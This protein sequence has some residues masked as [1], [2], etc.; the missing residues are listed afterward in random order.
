MRIAR[1]LAVSLLLGSA[2]ETGAQQRADAVLIV[3]SASARYAD[4]QSRVR[5]FLDHFGVPYTVLDIASAPV[6]PDVASYAL[7]II[8]HAGLD[9]AARYLD[10]SEQANI[11]SAVSQGTGLVNFDY[12]LAS[13]GTGR[14][15]YVQDLFGFGYRFATSGEGVLFTSEAPTHWIS[16]R[17]L[18]GEVNWARQMAGA[19]LAAPAG[20]TVLARFQD[21]GDP[22]LV[23]ASYGLGRAVQ[24]A[25]YEWMSTAIRGPV[26][27]LD[28]LVW[29][30]LAWAARKP[31]VMQGM[32]AF[33]TLRVDDAI[34]PFWWVRVANELSLKPWLG[35]FYQSITDTNAL[36]LAS[37]VSGG[38]ATASVHAFGSS[39]FYY[40]HAGQRDLP[41]ATMAANFQDATAWH[42]R[43]GIP[44]SSFVV[45]HFYEIGTNAFSG[46]RSWGV[47]SVATHM[48]PG[49]G[50]GSAWL[51]L[52]PYRL[53]EGGVSDSGLP[54]AYAD[55]LTIPGHPELANQ[56]FECV[57]E[58]RD[59][60]G[61]EW[62]PDATDV[63]GTIGRGTRQAKRALDSMA[64][65]TLFTHEYYVQS[66]TQ[67][68]W[69]STLRG[70]LA[71]LAPYEPVYVTMDHACEYL[72]AKHDSRIVASLFDPATQTLTTDVSGRADVATQ[73]LVFTEA[74]GV[75]SQA[76]AGVPAFTGSARVTQVLSSGTAPT[77]SSVAISPAGPTLAAGATL[78]LTATGAYSDGTSREVTAQVA[79]ASS[80]ASV[81]T[82]GAGG[83]A[84]GVAPGTTTISAALGAVSGSTTITVQ[85][86][87]L[88][89]TTSSLPS[90][91]RD[92]PYQATLAA[93]GGTPPYSWSI[94]SGALPAGLTLSPAGA[95][96]G[97]PTTSG[98][99][100]FAARVTDAASTSASKTLSIP[101]VT[102]AGLSLWPSTAVPATA[103][104]GADS[105]VELGV[106]FRSDASGFITGIR[107]YK[108][109]ANTGTH[110][111][112]LWTSSGTRLASATF[113]GETASGWQQV[114]FATPVAIS[115]GLTY[116]AS[117]HT[118][119][120]H[121]AR[122][123]NYFATA[124]WDNAPLHAPS[125]STSGGNGVFGYG[126]ASTFP[127]GS[128]LAANYWVDVVFSA[129]GP[130]TLSSVAV[131]PASPSVAAG[132]T[133]ALQ[134]VGTYSDGTTQDVTGQASWSSSAAAV[135][136]IDG[137][138]LLTA[139]A[140][141][142]ATITATIGTLTGSTS[143]T[144]T[145][146]PPTVTLAG[147]SLAS[148]AVLEGLATTGTVTL[149]GPAPADVAVALSIGA[150]ATVPATV[151]VPSGAT[152]A[153]F[154]VG[155]AAV[156]ATTA[157]TL[158]AT[159]AGV[160]RTAT[161]S[162]L[163][164]SLTL[165][166]TSV[167]GGTSATGTLT[168]SA[169]PSQ[170]SSI[171]LSSSSG[172]AATPASVTL[173][174][175]TTTVTFQVATSA[176]ASTTTA[177]VTA[178]TG[179]VM[180]SAV[181]TVNPTAPAATLASASV[182]PSA[183]VEGDGATGT[184][185]LTAA[186]PAGGAMVAL[187]SS[188][189]AATVPAAVTVPAGAT[190]ATFAIATSAVAAGT[191]AT[192]T[193]SYAGTNRTATLAIRALTLSLSPA[194]VGGG[195]SSTA[196]IRLSAAVSVPITA[197]VSSGNTAVAAV[198]ATVTVPAG[199]TSATFTV[200]TSSV[201]AT[202]TVAIAATYAG[203]AA[204]ASLS[205]RV[206]AP[207]AVS[208]SP[209][210]V[211]GGTPSTGTVTLNYPAPAGGFL[212]TLASSR[213]SAATVPASLTVPAG[214]RSA[215]FPITTFAVQTNTNTSIS[216]SSGGVKKS[217]TLS[218]TR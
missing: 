123:L 180:H 177:T 82:I 75:V 149:S 67:D 51:N 20:T 122:D 134:A 201:T 146:V 41:D 156:G 144:V 155:T 62:Y 108:S 145:A 16:N 158:T 109:T 200:T 124:G 79:W 206:I 117:Y 46:L 38:G 37:L 143:V 29:R 166:P 33:L 30:S 132:A 42:A 196:T 58:I 195:N 73:L 152:T 27:G 3:N 139:V 189:V 115:A 1:A 147:V 165:S 64:L 168:A 212:V 172:S 205:V 63:Q 59:D 11:T 119:T 48:A 13:S 111:G 209:S 131:T 210:T 77:L 159:A 23:V 185:T 87:P 194:T 127:D 2:A 43:V 188:S 70:V 28:D 198:P 102:S 125:S 99:A 60:A 53:F 184:V 129:G 17:H 218:V 173:A 8:G 207:S 114:S 31:F 157:A 74:G 85:A 103:D 19:S 35:L 36:D 183:V 80:S 49:Q 178:T 104:R 88:A 164:L 57:T 154:P 66:F 202:T 167:T 199:A 10:L 118:D 138:G 101:I 91:T 216:A 161:L 100:S 4:A 191:S 187:S 6:G 193:A 15:H 141:G 94:S 96:S 197:T 9:T 7:I 137:S 22:F 128:A 121:Y 217:A 116:V 52:G 72:R 55:Y 153:S 151:V 136:T 169:A 112:S 214:V 95:V 40:D 56:F 24:F 93:A 68:D 12:D 54:V 45:P 65:A 150:A 34:G 89:V 179:A 76:T 44:V 142:T 81:A 97:T 208:L 186:A 163:A 126:A 14:Y 130:A 215:T 107:F 175:G 92:V 71:N 181:L 133:L 170:A 211:V 135:A 190:S 18:A 171:A 83:L 84:T 110:V 176:V 98:T 61:Y 5:P 21:S 106:K 90:G 86:A 213:T 69:R 50:Y 25:S 192:L 182:S 47:R 26:R 32:P 140:G 203:I 39:F 113:T 204:S 174:A 78:Q 160:S 148:A 162:V 120:G 105:A